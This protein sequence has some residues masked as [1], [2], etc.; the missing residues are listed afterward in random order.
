MGCT[1]YV[2]KTKARIS[3]AFTAQLICAF[4]FAYADFWLSYAAAHIVVIGSFNDIRQRKNRFVLL[5]RAHFFNSENGY[6]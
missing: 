3:C 4:G 1:L 5:C 2:A 6:F